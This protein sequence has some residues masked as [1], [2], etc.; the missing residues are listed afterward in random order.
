MLSF[1][2]ST[3]NMFYICIPTFLSNCICLLFPFFLQPPV[4]SMRT[5]ASAYAITVHY[6]D[7]GDWDLHKQWT[8]TSLNESG[9]QGEATDY[10]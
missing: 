3:R 5:Q 4:V 8:V 7:E 2:N 1:E 9:R 10:K 6:H